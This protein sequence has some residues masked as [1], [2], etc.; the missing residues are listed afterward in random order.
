MM[1]SQL[2][3]AAIDIGSNAVRLLLSGVFEEAHLATFR[4]M[5]LIRMPI[6]L[7]DDAFTQK[8]I[9]DSKVS[10]LVKSMIGFKHLIEAFQPLDYMACATSA[11]REAEN[12]PE[13]CNRILAEADIRVDI[14]D[15]VREAQFIFEN[16]SADLFGGNDAYLYVDIGGG[17]TDITLFSRGRIIT[18]GSFNIGTIRLLEGLVSKAY[19]K[20]MR[21]WLKNYT[22]SFS[23][24]AAIGSGGNINKVFRLANCKNGKPLS[25]NKMMKVRRFLKH[26]TVEQRIKE[27]ALR[28]DR[29]DVI[30]PALDIYLKIMKW[31]SIRKIYVPQVG[32]A[33]GIVRIL[34]DRYK[35][36]RPETSNSSTK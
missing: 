14:I 15:G 21:Q 36:S 28:P 4:K 27:L 11:M 2:K 22:A 34:Y 16:K 13:I 30:I 17:S 10:Q 32:L 8:C 26:F 18:T 24:M 1:E 7:G 29:A 19:W 35:A 20:K 31:A 23:S 25:D 3:F 6:R 33:D 12:G 9:S 5:S